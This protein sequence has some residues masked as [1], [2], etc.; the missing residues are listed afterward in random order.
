[1]NSNKVL[2]M[3]N[4]FLS[5]AFANLDLL[6]Q[7]VKEQGAFNYNGYTLKFTD[8]DFVNDRDGQYI[9]LAKR[10]K[11]GI[12]IIQYDLIKKTLVLMQGVKGVVNKVDNASISDLNNFINHIN[13]LSDLD[14]ISTSY[15]RPEDE[16][17]LDEL[18]RAFRSSD[19]N[20]LDF[21]ERSLGIKI[22]HGE[23]LGVGAEGEVY[24]YGNDKIIKLFLLPD[25]KK[26]AVLSFLKKL[27]TIKSKHVSK[28]YHSGIAVRVGRNLMIADSATFENP[29]WIAYYI[30][31]KVFPIKGEKD[32]EK[33]NALRKSLI[34]EVG[35][36]PW[37]FEDNP[38]NIMQDVDGNYVYVDFGS[39]ADFL[40]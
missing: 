21:V 17:R 3:A 18:T 22:P 15:D 25:K 8:L 30:A 29:I 9:F 23:L 32:Q 20:L 14:E 16:L 36:D 1:M 5:L 35:L 39:V 19:T 28:I 4:K 24:D 38:D 37:D 7:T 11:D 33:V 40:K 10:L 26:D 13:E 2:R 6:A 12:V 31:D 27:E 34:D